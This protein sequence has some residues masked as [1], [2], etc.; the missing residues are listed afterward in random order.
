MSEI[1]RLEPFSFSV[2]EAA[3]LL[4]ISRQSVRQWV[5]SGKLTPFRKGRVRI[6]RSELEQFIGH[7]GPE[8]IFEAQLRAKARHRA[9]RL[10][11]AA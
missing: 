1:G 6:A 3:A 2:G 11:R 5:R 8:Q 9:E 10:K 7:I 4:G